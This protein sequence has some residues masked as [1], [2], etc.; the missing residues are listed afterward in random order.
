[1]NGADGQ[2]ALLQRPQAP[3]D[4]VP[5][6]MYQRLIEHD[7]PMTT[8][9]WA[10]PIDPRFRLAFGLRINGNPHGKGSVRVRVI[11]PKR[12]G[13]KARGIGRQAPKS[14]AYEAWL[15]ELSKFQPMRGDF[16]RKLTGPMIARVLAVK[17]RPTTLRNPLP[18]IDGQPAGRL[19]CPVTPDWDNIGKSVGD[20]LK[21][22]GV[23]RDDAAIV[24]GRVVTLYA[25]VDEAPFV[26]TF[27]WAVPT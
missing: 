21:K 14:K 2:L 18:Y 10:Q 9:A 17:R 13:G 5:E 11:P 3:D 1:M 26:E 20:G 15:A 4:Y 19:Y 7:T 23:I 6:G 24:D 27:V 8:P 12:P 22:G 25:A 16:T